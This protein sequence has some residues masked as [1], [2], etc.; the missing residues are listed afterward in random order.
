VDLDLVVLDGL[1]VEVVVDVTLDRLVDMV[2]EVVLQRVVLL[3]QEITI[4][5]VEDLEELTMDLTVVEVLVDPV[6]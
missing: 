4:V 6:L 3:I 2:E 1:L 5:V